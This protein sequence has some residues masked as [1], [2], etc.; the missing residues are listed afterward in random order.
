MHVIDQSTLVDRSP[1]FTGDQSTSPSRP[2]CD[3]RLVTL[4][5]TQNANA[6]FFLMTNFPTGVDVQIPGRIIGLVSDD[7]YFDTN[8]ASQWF[9][10]PRPVGNIPI[11]IRDYTANM[12]NLNEPA[13][14]RLI[15]TV[16]T[17]ENGYYE[18]LLPSTETFNCPIPQGPC[19]GMYL[20]TV[21]DPGDKGNPNPNYNPNYLTATFAWDVWPGLTTQLDTPLDPISGTG[22]DFSVGPGDIASTVPELLQVSRPY[23]LASNTDRRIAADHDPRRLH[24]PGRPD[25]CNR[26]TGHAHNQANGRRHAP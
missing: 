17:D 7:I 15:T 25:G 1:Y 20:V 4:E 23:V 11:G 3:K 8:P 22:C 24:R 6:D 18:A 2:L 5:N 10:E 26:R 21:N 13:L 12:N 9:G 19:P 14:G 16:T